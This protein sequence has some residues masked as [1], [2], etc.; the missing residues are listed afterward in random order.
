MDFNARPPVLYI[1]ANLAI[2]TDHE[3]GV[4]RQVSLLNGKY[5]D[6]LSNSVSTHHMEADV[7]TLSHIHASTQ[8]R[9]KETYWI[10]VGLIVTE[11][12]LA[13]FLGY[14]FTHSY[15]R[16]LTKDCNCK[17]ASNQKTQKPHDEN[18]STS[19]PNLTAREESNQEEA[20]P[21]RVRY[22]TYSLQTAWPD[23]WASHIERHVTQDSEV[24]M[25]T[26]KV[27]SFLW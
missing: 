24:H 2:A 15:V 27:L 19:Q 10:T 5:L 9:A 7:N 22:S 21:P 17:T 11:A 13:I 18:P 6:Q 23:G 14:H 4:L 26:V 20:L 16:T 12:I 3:T 1:P 25:L 8:G